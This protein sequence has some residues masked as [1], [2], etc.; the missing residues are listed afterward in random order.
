MKMYWWSG[1]IVPYILDLGT[2]WTW[3]VSFM[4]RPLYPHGNSPWY[5]LD[6]RLG[7]PQSRSGRDG[8]GKN[9]QPLPGL[10]HPNIQP[11]A[12]RYIKKEIG[13]TCSTTHWDSEMRTQFWSVYS[14]EMIRCGR[15][16]LKWMLYTWNVSMWTEL[17]WFRRGFSGGLLWT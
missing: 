14:K 15:M 9:S 2:I 10:E 5:H 8:G 6:R 11:V 12:Q 17:S 3:V 4:P 1:S 7:G 16:I 13:E